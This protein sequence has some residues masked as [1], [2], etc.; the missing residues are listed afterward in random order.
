[1]IAE[2]GAA[3]PQRPDELARARQL[4]QEE[5]VAGRH[6][7]HVALTAAKKGHA[8]LREAG[9]QNA[10]IRRDAHPARKRTPTTTENAAK[11]QAKLARRGAA[12]VPDAAIGEAAAG[13]G[14]NV[15][16]GA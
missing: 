11:A 5:G 2:G 15:G 3:V 6:D 14:R 1:M 10:P 8:H 16:S 7:A 12:A 13:A 9:D 4:D